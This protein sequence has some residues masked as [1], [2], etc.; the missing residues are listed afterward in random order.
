MHQKYT[1]ENDAKLKSYLQYQA[2]IDRPWLHNF[3]GQDWKPLPAK[4]QNDVI[5]AV[6]NIGSYLLFLWFIVTLVRT[7]TSNKS[8]TD[9]FPFSCFR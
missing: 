9:T 8:K 1:R 5:C 6:V 3:Y 7:L 4:R 2:F